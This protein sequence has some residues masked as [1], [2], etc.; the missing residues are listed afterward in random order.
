M[1]TE[2]LKMQL[3]TKRHEKK[4]LDDTVRLIM[5][6]LASLCLAIGVNLVYEPLEM[7]IGG[8]T[9]FSIAISSIIEKHT[10]VSL[11]VS[12]LNLI[13]NVPILLISVKQKGWRFFFFALSGT[14]FLSIMLAVIPIV[15][16]TKEDM[17]LAA[18]IGGALTGIGM[19][20]IFRSGLSTGG[21]DLI[22]TLIAGKIKRVSQ[23]VI[24]GIIDAIIVLLGL[25]VFG[26][27]KSIYAILALVVMTVVA[28]AVLIGFSYTKL[29][30]VV[31]DKGEE[32]SEEILKKIKR[33]VTFWNA[34]GAYSGAGKEVL[35]CACGG[36]EVRNLIRAVSEYDEKSFVVI[37]TAKE[38][39]GEG[40]AE[41]I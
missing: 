26:I 3:D 29:V 41:R 4:W 11:S 35:M 2:Q 15:P 25:S 23:S 27:Y 31:T 9:G 17:F 37:L 32:I 16:V 6:A 14:V 24:L 30:M 10:E 22:S 20:L 40:F 38:I 1:N 8:I 28:D 36:R 18:L 13:F 12:A 34:T 39:L 33:G 5:V 7:V 21:T 19:G